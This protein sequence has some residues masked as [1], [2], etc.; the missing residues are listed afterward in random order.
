MRIRESGQLKTRIGNDK[1]D[2]EQ[3]DMPPSY[4][5]LKNHGNSTSEKE[6]NKGKSVSIERKQGDWKAYKGETLAV[7][8]HDDR[9]RGASTCASSP[10]SESHTNND[11]KNSS[12]GRP[13]RGGSPSG[14]RLQKPCKDFLEGAGT[15]PS[16]YLWH[17]PVCRKVQKD[18]EAAGWF[19][20]KYSFLRSETDRQPNERRK[21][22]GRK[23]PVALK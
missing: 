22:S 11:G 18:K 19:G 20:E 6:K 10:T 14:R 21:N 16:C 17:Q 13:P 2:T 15:N 9:K 12:K 5:R 1:Q 4:Q 7:F 3:K 8:R 23:G